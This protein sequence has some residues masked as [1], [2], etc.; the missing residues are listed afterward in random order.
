M[1]FQL[2]LATHGQLAKGF[3]SAVE[4]IAGKQEMISAYTLGD[5]ATPQEIRE[6]VN[7]KIDDHPDE[8]F[9]LLTDILGGS[10]HNQLI[11]ECTRENVVL[12][13]GINLALVLD[14][15]LTPEENMDKDRVQSSISQAA[16]NLRFFDCHSFEDLQKGDNS[17]W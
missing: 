11:E 4:M 7:R 14:L 5:Y 2:I 9:I 10:V 16:N 3:V 12:V 15:L 17:L 1:K 13:S 6:E 8:L